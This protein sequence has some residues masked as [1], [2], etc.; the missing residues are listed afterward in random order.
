MFLIDRH[1]V[2]EETKKAKQ[3]VLFVERA[4][5]WLLKTLALKLAPHIWVLNLKI[6]NIGA[7][8][9]SIIIE[10]FKRSKMMVIC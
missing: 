7:Y 3:G 4:G 6:V 8:S 5:E 10:S 2:T 1:E 9:C